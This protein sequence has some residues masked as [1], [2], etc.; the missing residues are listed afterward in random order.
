MVKLGWRRSA[1]PSR[2]FTVPPGRRGRFVESPR[3]AASGPTTAGRKLDFFGI[4]VARGG[5]TT[6]HFLL[7]QHPDVELPAVRKELHYF[8][9]DELFGPDNMPIAGNYGSLHNWVGFGRR[10]TGEITPRYI[11]YGGCLER[12]RAYNPEARLIA[13]LRNP[14]LRAHSD[15]R[16]TRKPRGRGMSFAAQIAADCAVLEANPEKTPRGNSVGRSRYGRQIERVLS[17]FPPN[18]VMFVKS[19]VFFARQAEVAD[20]ICAFLGISPLSSH[21]TTGELRKNSS[22]DEPLSRDDWQRVYDLVETDI[23]AVERILGWDCT[24]WRIPPANTA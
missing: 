17:L 4:G 13:L 23:T 10:L 2:P 6:L 9:E 7:A 19:E 12:I 16:R 1:A 22:K 18:R 11:Y 24:D 8:D 20:E 15:W 5:T 14:V 3:A 21:S